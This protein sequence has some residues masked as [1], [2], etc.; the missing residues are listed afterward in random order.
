[1]KT[2]LKQYIE[3]VIEK[4]TITS[5]NPTLKIEGDNEVKSEN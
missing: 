4:T 5:K 1:M 3:V 2:R